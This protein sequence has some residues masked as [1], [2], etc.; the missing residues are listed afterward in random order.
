MP[1][2]IAKDFLRLVGPF[3]PHIAEE[4]WQRLGEADFI[5]RATWPTYDPALTVGETI[6]IPVQIN[7]RLRSVITVETD[8]D[9]PTLEQTA[10]A[11]AVI[12][13]HIDGKAVKR[14]II[15][16]GRMVNVIV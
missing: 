1:I 13:R 6:E 3:A 12:Q 14:V 15:V 9:N 11:D 10:L 5:A 4:L 7:G 8:A 2:P 16:P